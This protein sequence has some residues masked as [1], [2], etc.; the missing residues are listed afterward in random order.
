MR[1]TNA[2][3]LLREAWNRH[4][5]KEYDTLLKMYKEKGYVV[6]RNDKTGEHIVEKTSN[7]SDM[8]A[9]TPFENLFK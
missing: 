7:V 4:Y 1:N 5:N 8:F 3:K 2:E 9:G 6:K